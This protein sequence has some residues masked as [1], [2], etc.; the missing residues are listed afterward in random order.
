MSDA[1]PYA[2]AGDP[3]YMAAVKRRYDFD[4][5]VFAIKKRPEGRF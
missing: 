3:G 2:N 1:S 4:E 5:G